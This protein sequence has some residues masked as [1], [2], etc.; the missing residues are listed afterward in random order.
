MNKY[1][2]GNKDKMIRKTLLWLIFIFIT[3]Y[4]FG[5]ITS[6]EAHPLYKIDKKLKSGDKNAFFEIAPYFDSKKELTERFAYN[7]ISATKA[8]HLWRDEFNKIVYLCKL[9]LALV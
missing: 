5:Q 8:L 9:K 3:Q 7:H 4:S 1:N 6:N 2:F